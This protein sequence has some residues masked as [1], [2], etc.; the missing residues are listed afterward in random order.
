MRPNTVLM[1]VHNIREKAWPNLC[2]IKFGDAMLGRIGALVEATH[3]LYR[4]PIER[5][6]HL[7]EFMELG[8]R[9]REVAAARGSAAPLRGGTV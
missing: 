5:R 7:A 6:A 3:A 9:E 2:L 8:G 4:R 1:L